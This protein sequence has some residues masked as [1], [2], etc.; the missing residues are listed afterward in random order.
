MH[1][2]T[3][4]GVGYRLLSD[5]DRRVRFETIE[6]DD[7]N[8]EAWYFIA[9]PGRLGR[10]DRSLRLWDEDPRPGDPGLAEVWFPPTSTI[11]HD[12]VSETAWPPDPGCEWADAVDVTVAGRAAQRFTCGD[13]ELTIDTDTGLPLAATWVDPNGATTTLTAS[14]VELGDQ[15]PDAFAFGPS[16]PG[17]MVLDDPAPTTIPGIEPVDAFELSRAAAAALFELPPFMALVH[18]STASKVRW[19]HDGDGTIRM[20]HFDSRAAAAPSVAW[21]ARKGRMLRQESDPQGKPVFVEHTD[22]G[23]PRLEFGLGLGQDCAGP[24]EYHGLTLVADRPAHHITTCATQ[25]WID[26]ETLFVL[27]SVDA[28]RMVPSPDPAAAPQLADHLVLGTVEFVV[29]PQP[30]EL[31]DFERFANGQ[32]VIT[33]AEY[34]CLISPDD[35]SQA[36]EP[37]VEVEPL[38]RPAAAPAPAGASTSADEVVATALATHEA[39]PPISMLVREQTLT[40]ERSDGEVESR[41]YYDGADGVRHEYDWD[42]ASP[43]NVPTVFLQVGDREY[44]SWSDDLMTWRAREVDPDAQRYRLA[45]GID[46]PCTAGWEHLGFARLLD[47]T[48]HHLRCEAFELWVDVASSMV[49]RSESGTTPLVDTARVREVVELEIGPQPTELFELPP[50][51]VVEEGGGG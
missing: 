3:P 23:D 42:L 45:M 15:P 27:R 14:S 44:E 6:T 40:D 49:L 5:G 16:D 7:P 25:L 48:V 11:W 12:G 29:G 32:Q 17:I 33:A 35:C 37:I 24:W 18:D 43:D 41:Y 39:L 13:R 51:A 9:E 36:E 4:S 20:E 8:A 47:R 34:L 26:A 50:D 1:L 30:A 19:Y 22:Q 21:I 28:S 10:G 46:R 38:P 2:E 31:F